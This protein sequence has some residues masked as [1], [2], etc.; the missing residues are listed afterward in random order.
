[1]ILDGWGLAPAGPTNAI[2]VAHTPNFNHLWSVFPHLK[3]VAS[4]TGVGLPFGQMGNSEVGHMAIGAGRILLQDL[5]RISNAI[6]DGTFFRNVALLEIF[7]YARDNAKPI[8]LIG[9]VS[10]GGVHS[11][12]KHLYALLSM[13]KQ[14]KVH[15]VFVHVI[16]DGRDVDPKSGKESVL[17]LEK[18]MKDIGVGKIA[19]VCGRYFAMDRDNRWDRTELT[20]RAI[21][22]GKGE[23]A[24]SAEEAVE[25]NYSLG[26]HDEFIHPTI[27]DKKGCIGEGDA[28]IFFNFRSDRPRQL[29]R[30]LI[31]SKFASFTREKVAKKLK[32]VTFT[33][34]EKKLPVAGVAF[35]EEDVVETLADVISEHNLT[36]FHIAETEKYA[37]VTYY[38]EGGREQ[39]ETGE[40]RTVIPSPKVATYDEKPEMSA[41]G[42]GKELVKQIGKYDFIIVNFANPDMVGHTGKM[43]AAVKAVE[44]VD[45]VLGDVV[46]AAYQKGYDVVVIADHGNAEKM[47]ETDGTPCTSHT[48]AQVPFILVSDDEHVLTKIAEPKLANIAPTILMLM[49]LPVPKQMTERS[50]IKY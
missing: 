7:K 33:E 13:A 18:E 11:H 25:N 39:A 48:T 42:V 47:A 27:V 32:L 45:I 22:E 14:E 9:L 17:A 15:D 46:E 19:T 50:L 28:A 5:P 40:D 16:T 1:M 41:P 23:F 12:E 34:Y 24:A 38:F 44:A 49:G 30:A 4:G 37:H 21:V 10:P 29:V 43:A 36:Q 35:S 31:E 20:Y 3:L 2:S 6:K 8:H 26:N